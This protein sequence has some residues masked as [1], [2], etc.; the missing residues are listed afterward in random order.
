[1]LSVTPIS[2]KIRFIRLYLSHSLLMQSLD[3]LGQSLR[4]RFVTHLQSRSPL[5]L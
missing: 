5:N 3:L 4:L 2:L 1:M